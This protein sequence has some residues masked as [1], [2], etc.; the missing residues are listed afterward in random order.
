MKVIV[1]VCMTVPVEV[2]VDNKYK[3]LAKDDNNMTWKD[4]DDLLGLAFDKVSKKLPDAD[5][6]EV[7]AVKTMRGEL[8]AE[9]L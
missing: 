6:L 9:P 4:V 8:L 5:A 7:K 2:E 3:A 1:E